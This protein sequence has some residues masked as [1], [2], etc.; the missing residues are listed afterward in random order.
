MKHQARGLQEDFHSLCVAHLLFALISFLSTI[1]YVCV[2]MCPFDC[3]PIVS[4]G[5]C[6]FPGGNLDLETSRNKPKV[7]QA[8]S[9]MSP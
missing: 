4:E 6:V 5:S 3:T 8:S 1:R 2:P 7:S 9:Q